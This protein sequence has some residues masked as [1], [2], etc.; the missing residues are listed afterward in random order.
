M[1]DG[2]R[3]P[4]QSIDAERALLGS[5]MLKPDGIHEVTDLVSADSFY[6]EKHRAIYRAMIG[7]ASSGSPIDLVSV[8]GRLKDEGGLE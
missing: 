4:P 1:T 3:I 8:S 5:V 6:V 7:L 2:S